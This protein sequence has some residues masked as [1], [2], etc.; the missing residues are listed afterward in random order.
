MLVNQFKTASKKNWH[1]SD[2]F[3]NVL[4]QLSSF[5]TA[6]HKWA[7]EIGAY[8]NDEEKFVVDDATYRQQVGAEDWP[9]IA[10]ERE[11]YQILVK[12]R[13]VPFTEFA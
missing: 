2:E 6:D 10:R 7:V 8:D 5:D 1:L 4:A 13:P 12:I 3:L 11:L 9:R